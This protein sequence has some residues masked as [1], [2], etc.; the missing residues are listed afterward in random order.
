MIAS[1][2]VNG[3]YSIRTFDVVD[4]TDY[5]YK[6]YESWRLIWL[7]KEDTAS[8]RNTLVFIGLRHTHN[9]GIVITIQKN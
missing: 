8:T 6:C 3:R 5:L 4:V 7:Y 1:S 9:K 2:M